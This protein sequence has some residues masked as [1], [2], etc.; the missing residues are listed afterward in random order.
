MGRLHPHQVFHHPA[1]ALILRLLHEEKAW[2]KLSGGYIVSNT[3]DVNDPNLNKLAR[4]FIEASPHRVVWGSDWPHATASAGHCPMP[5]D[6]HQLDRLA[7]WARDES[8][9]NQILV[10]NPEIGRA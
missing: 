4:S 5:N 10:I 9:F 3:G 2:L 8:L 1:H 6:A 7:D